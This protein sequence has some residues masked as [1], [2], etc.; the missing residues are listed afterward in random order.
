MSLLKRVYR[1]PKRP[2]AQS[3]AKRIQARC[4][5]WSYE[6]GLSA[7]ESSRLH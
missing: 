6:S 7:N 5:V 4:R 1:S 2:T 3:L